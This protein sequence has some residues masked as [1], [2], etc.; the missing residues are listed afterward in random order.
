MT[1]KIVPKYDLLRQARAIVSAIPD[2]RFDLD[3]IID[4]DSLGPGGLVVQGCGT[5]ACALGWLCLNPTFNEY[6]LRLGRY[7]N[8]IYN[9][10]TMYYAD[11]ASVLFN[12]SQA[13]AYNLFQPALEQELPLD[14]N[15][16][17]SDKALWL[18]RLDTF[19]ASHGQL[20][21]EAEV[22]GK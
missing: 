19:M 20:S 15:G 12:M 13:D 22:V 10:M 21:H 14:T 7:G 3:D 18:H 9:D 16:L 17:I 5:I 1:K 11:A 2:E 8:V 4:N 6:G